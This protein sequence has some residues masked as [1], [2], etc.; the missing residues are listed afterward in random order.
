MI[1]FSSQ[2]GPVTTLTSM[3]NC[4]YF[5]VIVHLIGVFEF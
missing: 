4:P 1:F 5:N 3:W 2:G